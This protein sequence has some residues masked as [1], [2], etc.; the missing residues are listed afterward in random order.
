MRKENSKLSKTIVQTVS[1]QVWRDQINC[2]M[3]LHLA[4]T[5][6]ARTSWSAAQEQLIQIDQMISSETT[7]L[8]LLLLHAYLK[9]VT[10]QGA[11]DLENA[12]LCYQ[13]P[14]LALPEPHQTSHKSQFALDISILS[15]LNTV[16][17]ISSP[18]HSQHHLFSSFLTTLQPFCLSNPNRQIQSA[19]HLIAAAT[20]SS[21]TILSTKQS[22]QS[23]LQIAKQTSNNQLMCMVLNFM[24][25]KFFRGVVGDQAEKS[26]MASQSL[27]VKCMDKLWMSVSAGVLGDAYEA[28]GRME[29]ADKE[30]ENGFQIARSLPGGVQQAMKMAY[31]QHD[32]P[33]TDDYDVS[34]VQV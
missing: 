22:L 27:A 1:Q 7:K 11:G 17:I 24:S 25:W 31:E 16:L 5:L 13:S 2:Y 14:L 12:F 6:C 34:K 33:M 20:P 4:M 8:P 9:G 19:Y 30:R 28:A 29:D 21:S 23:A 15:A 3:Q 26:A 32:M 18:S 10:Q